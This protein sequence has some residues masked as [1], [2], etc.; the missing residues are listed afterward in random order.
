MSGWFILLA[1]L[2][3][4]LIVGAWVIVAVRPRDRRSSD[5]TA[6]YFVTDHRQRDDD[7]DVNGDGGD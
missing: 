6:G 5:T 1:V 2:A 7:D 4:M 3:V